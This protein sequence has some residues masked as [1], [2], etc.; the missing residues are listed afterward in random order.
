[1]ARYH[2]CHG[3]A[4]PKRKRRGWCQLDGVHWHRLAIRHIQPG[5]GPLLPGSHQ[6]GGILTEMGF[7]ALWGCPLPKGQQIPHLTPRGRRGHGW[8]SSQK[9]LVS[10]MALV[11]KKTLV[12]G[13][14][15]VSKLMRVLMSFNFWEN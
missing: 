2:F 4:D 15:L 10:K 12:L 14:T 7:D 1:M 11:S 13:L 9:L 3:G 6:R 8:C 5:G